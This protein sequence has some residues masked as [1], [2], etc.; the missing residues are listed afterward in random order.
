MSLSSTIARLV[1]IT[2]VY[3]TTTN[4]LIFIFGLIGNTLNIL[5]F[6]KLKLF[7]NNQC[8]FYLTIESIININFLTFNFLLRFL[9]T[10]YGSD[11]TQYSSIWCK[12]KVIISQTLAL[13]ALYTIC[14]TTI[15][16]FF[17]TSYLVNLRKISTL[18]LAR[19]LVIISLCFSLCHSICFGSFFNSKLPADCA[20]T[21]PI[22]I[23]YYS[24]FFFPILCG[25][26]PLL[27]S[28]LVSFFAYRNVRRI[29]QRQ[30]PV[31]RRRLDQQLTKFVLIRVIFLVLFVTPIVIYRIY[32]TKVIINP[33][34]SLR[35]AI[36]RLVLAIMYSLFSMNYAINFYIFFASSSRY[37]R[38]MKYVLTK[39]C[40]H[41]WKQ[42]FSFDRNQIHPL[43]IPSVCS[44]EHE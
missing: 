8:I 14:F 41:Y 29:I 13:F 16:Q 33:N 10:L 30:L 34:D 4:F 11:L 24:Y 1:T 18:K 20:L 5:V 15:D 9:T 22:L 2:Q 38:Q 39:K 37:R 21:N 35:L 17:S 36:E 42:R 7:Q 26:L 19:L 32:T 6:T 3:T 25:L 31:L 27:I 23:N 28:S 43:P 12:I 40:W 44:I